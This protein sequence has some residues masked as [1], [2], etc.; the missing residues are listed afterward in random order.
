MELEKVAN[1]ANTFLNEGNSGSLFRIV[2]NYI[3]QADG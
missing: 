2:I 3:Y 1:M